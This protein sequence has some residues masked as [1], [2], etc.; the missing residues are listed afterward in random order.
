MAFRNIIESASK[1]IAG[2][3]MEEHHLGLQPIKVN[4]PKINLTLT[5]VHIKHTFL[6]QVALV[7]G[8]LC[9]S[10]VEDC[11]T[12]GLALLNT[13][14]Q[15]KFKQPL[16]PV[17]VD[18]Q[19]YAQPIQG[20]LLEIINRAV[21]MENK[22]QQQDNDEK[23]TIQISDDKESWSG[24]VSAPANKVDSGD[25]SG[26]KLSV[27]TAAVREKEGNS[28]SGSGVSEDGD[29]SSGKVGVAT[30]AAVREKEGNDKSGAGVSEVGDA[31]DGKVGVVVNAAVREKEANDKSAAGIS[32][33]GDASGGKV[34]VV[35]AAKVGVA[36]G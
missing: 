11:A 14:S 22:L 16:K 28:T 27:P 1:I 6:S 33:V 13:S 35:S 20:L 8:A 25:A 30:S 17:T 36:S 32:E 23:K 2:D 5:E 4:I 3:A 19:D 9:L 24:H 18:T 7:V 21:K 26:V 31:S 34:S 15:A 10:I 29:A 12:T